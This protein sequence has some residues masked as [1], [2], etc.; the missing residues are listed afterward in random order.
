MKSGSCCF[1]PGEGHSRGLL[2]D[3]ETSDF[4]KVRFQL[5]SGGRGNADSGRANESVWEKGKQTQAAQARLS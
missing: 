3:C 5:Y 4:A 1:Q 2:S